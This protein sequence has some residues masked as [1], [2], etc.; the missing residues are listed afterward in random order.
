MKTDYQEKAIPEDFPPDDKER[1]KLIDEIRR[2]DKLLIKCCHVIYALRRLSIDV[3]AGVNLRELA[4][5]FIEEDIAR[6]T[7]NDVK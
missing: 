2:K 1:I 6:K 7:L 5:D 4:C 3:M